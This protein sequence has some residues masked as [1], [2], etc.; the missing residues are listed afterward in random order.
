MW[1]TP[2]MANAAHQKRDFVGATCVSFHHHDNGHCQSY[3]LM[4]ILIKYWKHDEADANFQ[5]KKP[6]S[7]GM[8]LPRNNQLKRA[9]LIL[10]IIIVMEIPSQL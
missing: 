4:Y 7:F 5:L 2:L 6:K 8:F 9:C 1:H 10:T 3:S